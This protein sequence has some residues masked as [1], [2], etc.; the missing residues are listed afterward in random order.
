MNN[1]EYKLIGYYDYL[2][3][4]GPPYKKNIDRETL[5]FFEQEEKVR[6]TRPEV[7]AKMVEQRLTIVQE[8]FHADL[9]HKLESAEGQ[10]PFLVE[11]GMYPTVKQL[12]KIL[13]T[14]ERVVTHH[15]IFLQ[16]VNLISFYDEEAAALIISHTDPESTDVS[17]AQAFGHLN[18][19]HRE[20][21]SNM[22]R[23]LRT[24]VLLAVFEDLKVF[25][26]KIIHNPY[27]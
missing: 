16:K 24:G 3:G 10:F 6:E 15:M 2:I 9:I 20:V 21:L 25:V 1:Y 19:L 7:F 5:K 23:T 8:L 14:T 17:R 13:K 26:P 11:V 22:D 4:E 18:S 27:Q 12:A